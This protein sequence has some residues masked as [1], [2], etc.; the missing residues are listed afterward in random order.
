[1]LFWRQM[2]PVLSMIYVVLHRSQLPL[3]VARSMTAEMITDSSGRDH[4]DFHL[5]LTQLIQARLCASFSTKLLKKKNTTQKSYLK[6]QH[7]LL[8]GHSEPLSSKPIRYLDKILQE[9]VAFRQCVMKFGQ[10]KIKGS[11][12]LHFI[13]AGLSDEFSC[14]ALPKADGTAPSQ[15]SAALKWEAM[16]VLTSVFV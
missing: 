14:E 15:M 3:V 10:K 9:E 12:R 16:T 13:F 7:G 8:F 11:G 5:P 4:P 6:V 1:M 2:S